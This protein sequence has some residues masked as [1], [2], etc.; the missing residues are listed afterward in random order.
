VKPIAAKKITA[1]GHNDSEYQGW[2]LLVYDAMWAVGY[3]PTLR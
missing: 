2:G 3:A 1:V